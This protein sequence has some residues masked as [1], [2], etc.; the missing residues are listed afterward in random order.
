MTTLVAED[1]KSLPTENKEGNDKSSASHFVG[2][3]VVGWLQILH[4]E[5]IHTKTWQ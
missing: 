3:H 4:R 1:D 5:T 2:C